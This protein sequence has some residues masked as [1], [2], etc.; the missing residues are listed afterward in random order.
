MLYSLLRGFLSN[1]VPFSLLCSQP[2]NFDPVF[3]RELAAANTPIIA[4]N[5][6]QK[7]FIGEQISILTRGLNSDA[8]LFPNYFTPPLIP[9]RLGRVATI[10]HDFLYAER[11]NAMSRQRRAW[12]GMTYWLTYSRADV[13]I[14]PSNFVRGRACELYGTIASKK[15]V[16]IPNPV[17]W[18]RFDRMATAAP[19][20]GRPYILTVAAHYPHKN[21]AVL[22][23][24]FA[25]LR[26]TFP[27][28]LLVMSGQLPK[29]LLGI[30][31]RTDYVSQLIAELDL[32]RYV[33]T[34]GYLDDMRLSTLYQ[35][36]TVFAFPSLFEGFGIPAVESLGF[37]LPTLTTKLGSLPEVTMGAAY[38]VDDPKSIDEWVDKLAYLLRNAS[39][40]RVEQARIAKLR[41]RYAPSRIATMYEHTLLSSRQN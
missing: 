18:D 27:D 22:V 32:Q 5:S 28:L 2:N 37:G 20:E 13:V 41:E 10:I 39:N 15:T 19:F 31:D 24:A 40:C 8:I 35:H 11:W 12:Q 1:G 6:R 29:D 7:R 34:T 36:A 33:I 16:T 38:Y 26:R 25:R 30:Q 9:H 3:T 21:L 4:S 14:V 23:R 17:D